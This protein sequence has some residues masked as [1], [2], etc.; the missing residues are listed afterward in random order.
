MGYPVILFL[1]AKTNS[2][3][4]EFSTSNF[5]AL[6]KSKNGESYPY[7]YVTPKSRSI[8]PS[9]TNRSLLELA[10]SLGWKVERRKVEWEEI[11]N[12]A[13]DEVVAC[14]TAV[15]IV[16]IYQIDIQIPVLDRKEVIT[17]SD[18]PENVKMGDSFWDFDEPQTEF[19]YESHV[20]GDGINYPG[21]R[22]LFDLYR[23]I[24]NG[25]SPDSFEWMCPKDGIDLS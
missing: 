18:P 16:P 11:K 21:F 4:E 24:Q 7:T 8:L 19:L 12:N 14:G 3:V 6:I 10:F 25:N 23:A 2:L 17:G 13:F 15:V 22:E 5:S 20:I 9:I 1:D